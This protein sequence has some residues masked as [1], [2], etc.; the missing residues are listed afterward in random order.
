MGS[1]GMSR[2]K[3]RD[4]GGVKVKD[5]GGRGR[6]GQGTREAPCHPSVARVAGGLVDVG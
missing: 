3:I 5:Q 2:F 1:W 4:H 6:L